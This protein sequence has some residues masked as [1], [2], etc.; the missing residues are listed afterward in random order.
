M[1]AHSSQHYFSLLL[2]QLDA[3][4]K[5]IHDEQQPTCNFFSY[6]D[7]ATISRCIRQFYN[8]YANYNIQK[9]TKLITEIAHHLNKKNKYNYEALSLVR[10]ALLSP[11][12]AEQYK[13][14]FFSHPKSCG[15]KIKACEKKLLKGY[16]E[17]SLT[18]PYTTLHR[19]GHLR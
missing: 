16:T 10:F 1:P 4:N 15:E 3:I 7:H 2:D 18:I 8:A 13:P 6:A 9:M 19:N 11:L 17:N 14:Y 5:K 12:A